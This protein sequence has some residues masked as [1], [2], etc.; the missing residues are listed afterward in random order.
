MLFDL[1]DGGEDY[2]LDNNNNREASVVKNKPIKNALKS[3]LQCYLDN[4]A[5]KGDAVF[6]VCGEEPPETLEPETGSPSGSPTGS[7]SGSPT[8]SPT[9]S[10]TAAPKAKCKDSSLKAII[11]NSFTSCAEFKEKGLCTNNK[12]WGHCRKS[13]KKCKKCRDSKAKF[14][15]TIPGTNKKKKKNCKFVKNNMEL[16]DE[17]GVFNACGQ[18]CGAC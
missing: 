3:N 6:D 13:C 12:Y 2:I 17:V 11:N 5:P 7:P 18:T 4:T 8:G 16:C 15:V 10:P 14:R 9:K 1:C